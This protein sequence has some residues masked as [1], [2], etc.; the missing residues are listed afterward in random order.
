MVYVN[1][2]LVFLVF[3]ILVFIGF[4]IWWSGWGSS[5]V[6]KKEEFCYECGGGCLGN[7]C[8]RL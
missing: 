8:I 5:T 3:I 2:G 1:W 4:F 7:R 6:G